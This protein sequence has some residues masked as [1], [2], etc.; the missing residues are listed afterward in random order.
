[1]IENQQIL[2]LVYIVLVLL[3]LGVFIIVFV[4]AFQRR[5]NKLLLEKFETEKKFEQELAQSQIEIQ[6]QTLKTSHG[7]LHDNVGQL[8]RGQHATGDAPPQSEELLKKR[9][10]FW[11]PK[12]PSPQVFLKSEPF[13]VRWIRE[14]VLNNGLVKSIQSE[15]ERFNQLNFNASIHGS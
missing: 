10:T 7:E 14:V 5:K 12:R 9:T 13:R 3:V 15:L 11:K 6:E 2:L 1:M 8:L 4:V